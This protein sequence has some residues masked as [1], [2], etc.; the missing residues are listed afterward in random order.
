VAIGLG[1]PKH[2]RQFGDKLA[3]SI[4]CLTNEEPDLY[5]AFG[6]G[7]G[8]PL[9]LISPDAIKAGARAASQGFTQ[10]KATGDAMRLTATFIVDEQGIVRY[11]HYGKHAGDHADIDEVLASWRQE[12][13]APGN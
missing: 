8:N 5:D 1:Q 11:A 13:P 2:A 12:S 3:P 4:L 10:G 6:I 7:R 9:R